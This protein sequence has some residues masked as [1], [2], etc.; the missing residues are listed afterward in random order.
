[1]FDFSNQNSRKEIIYFILNVFKVVTSKVILPYYKNL[2]KTE[3]DNKIDKNDFVTF[4][5]KKTEEI[6]S[7]YL[8]KK[9]SNIKIIG[10]ESSFQKNCNLSVFNDEYYWTI[11]P[12]DGTK[13]YIKGDKNFCSMISLVKQKK[14]IV[15]FIF[16]PLKKYLV[17]AFDNKGCYYFH[18]DSKITKNIKI[19]TKNT[20]YFGTGSTKGFEEQLRKKIINNLNFNTKRIFIGSAGIEALKLINNEINYILHGRVTPWDH[21]PINLI[22]KE[23]GGFAFMLKKQKLFDIETKGSFLATDRMSS[24]SDLKKI[25]FS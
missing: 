7:N 9:F 3:I 17:Y 8:T 4:A 14:P 20:K 5:D 23:S 10:E 6:I 1:M 16:N 24:W 18:L 19:K 25:I 21:S 22:I 15:A 13:N 2:K 11:D 12:I